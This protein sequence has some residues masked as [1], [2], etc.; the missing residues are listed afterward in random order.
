MAIVTGEATLLVDVSDLDLSIDGEGAIKR[1]QV[2]NARVLQ[3]S[4]REFADR[5]VGS[6]GLTNSDRHRTYEGRMRDFYFAEV[7][8]EDVI[9]Y[10]NTARADYFEFGTE[11]HEIWASGL[12]QS[13][14]GRRGQSRGTRGQFTTGAR[15]LAFRFPSG[16]FGIFEKVDHPGQEAMPIMA[17]ALEDSMD[18]FEEN[19]LREVVQE[20][21]RG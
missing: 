9:G 8:G 5:Y 6:R 13:N 18:T 19:A 11:A 15:A 12:S 17:W 2:Q 14:A 20:I 10:N 21:E 1:A 7:Q 16:D 4:M 3:E